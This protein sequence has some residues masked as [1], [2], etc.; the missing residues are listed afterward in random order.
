MTVRKGARGA[1]QSA[2]GRSRWS[3]ALRNSTFG[4][5]VRRISRQYTEFG[6]TTWTS[7]IRLT[8]HVRVHFSLYLKTSLLTKSRSWLSICNLIE[9]QKISLL[10]SLWKRDLG[11]F[12]N[13][14]SFVNSS[15]LPWQMISFPSVFLPFDWNPRRHLQVYLLPPIDSH[16]A[17]TE[18]WCLLGFEHGS[19]FATRKRRKKRY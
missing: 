9:I 18:H 13:G 1:Y 2:F 3:C 5:Q 16:S 4:L 17:L 6:K 11:E 14:L 19:P 15:K 10:D 12:G 8:G 7:N